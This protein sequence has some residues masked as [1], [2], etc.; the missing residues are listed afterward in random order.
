MKEKLSDTDIER[1]KIRL[2]N[3][4]T[5]FSIASDYDVSEAHIWRIANA[6]SRRDIPWPD[7]TLGPLPIER[8]HVGGAARQPASNVP[9]RVI[10]REDDDGFRSREQT[11]IEGDQDPKDNSNLSSDYD[12]DIHSNEPIISRD[13]ANEQFERIVDESRQEVQQNDE[14]ETA[15]AAIHVG[16]S[17]TVERETTK[18][19]MKQPR[20]DWAIIEEQ[21]SDLAIVKMTLKYPEL[22]PAIQIVFYQAERSTW[23]TDSVEKIVYQVAEQMG[24]NLEGKEE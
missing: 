5:Q 15:R 11:A 7:G 16:S 24:I 14:L 9:Q 4:D 19:D 21:A 10:E 1:I 17:E 22:K 13:D 20:L 6:R 2:W 23:H 12:N 8:R 18:I 3:G